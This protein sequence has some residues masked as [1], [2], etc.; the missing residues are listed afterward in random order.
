[1][2]ALLLHPVPQTPSQAVAEG[3]SEGV[4]EGSPLL[5]LLPCLRG[6]LAGA[7]CDAYLVFGS[8]SLYSQS[9][10]S[11]FSVWMH[12]ITRTI[13]LKCPS[14]KFC[15]SIFTFFFP[16]IVEIEFGK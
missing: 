8:C 2:K 10:Y 1:M 6:F 3:A 13:L 15:F 11:V 14:K 16:S 9:L 4:V 7:H 12:Q 5:R